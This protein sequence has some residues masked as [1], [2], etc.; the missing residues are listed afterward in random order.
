MLNR[1]LAPPFNRSTSFELIQPQKKILEGGAEAYF[2]LGGTQEVSK[3]EIVFAA[4]RWVE[5]NWGASYFTSNLLSKGTK[6]KTSSEIAH[7]LDLYGAHLEINPGLDFVSV[8]LYILNKN[9]EPAILLF[10]ELLK[11]SV[12]TQ[13]ESHPGLCEKISLEKLIP[14]EKNLMKRIFTS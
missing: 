7:L 4:G 8:S 5:K 9:F 10:L 12:F 6:K 2:T 1:T 3:V 11:E 14:M 13:Q